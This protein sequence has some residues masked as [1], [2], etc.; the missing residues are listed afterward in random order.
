MKFWFNNHHQSTHMHFNIYNWPN[1]RI[2]YSR[3]P[4]G[5][6]LLSEMQESAI[7]EEFM[8]KKAWPVLTSNI[9][10][11]SR[12]ASVEAMSPSPFQLQTKQFHHGQVCGV[13][14]INKLL[15]HYYYVNQILLKVNRILKVTTNSKGQQVWVISRRNNNRK[16]SSPLH[17]RNQ[18]RLENKAWL[19]SVAHIFRRHYYIQFL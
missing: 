4:S 3:I 12:I 5:I 2:R 15:G 13:S 17:H 11:K 19:Y 16:G 10:T 6:F 14:Q 7:D 8:R 1:N 9:F 18:T